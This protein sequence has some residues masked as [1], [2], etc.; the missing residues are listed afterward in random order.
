MQTRTKSAFLLLT[1]L[2]LTGETTLEAYEASPH[3][4]ASAT[5]ALLAD[6]QHRDRLVRL[7]RE[8]A[9]KFSWERAAQATAAVLRDAA[10]L[11]VD[12]ED[13]FRA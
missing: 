13:E 11:P 7:G 10:G 4:I 5:A 1:V 8:R 9:G 6:S 12:G 2:V 3:G